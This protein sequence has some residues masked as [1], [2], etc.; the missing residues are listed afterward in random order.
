MCR[1]LWLLSVSEIF[2][3]FHKTLW[4]RDFTSA[5]APFFNCPNQ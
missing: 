2:T 5:S 1:P 3:D 4:Q